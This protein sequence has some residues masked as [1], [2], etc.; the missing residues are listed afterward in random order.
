MIRRIY[1]QFIAPLT[2][3]LERGFPRLVRCLSV[4]CSFFF[5]AVFTELTLAKDFR[6]CRRIDP[7]LL[8]AFDYPV[9]EYKESDA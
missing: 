5:F 7:H 6:L 9:H 1:L 8:F 3:Y 4:T 2:I